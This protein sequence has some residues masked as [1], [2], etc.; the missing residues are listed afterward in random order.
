VVL[1]SLAVGGAERIV[2]DWAQRISADYDVH[3]CVLHK[4]DVEWPVRGGITVTRLQG[5]NVERGLT[6]FAEQLLSLS[7]A[8]GAPLPRVLCHMTRRGHREVLERAGVATVAVLHNALQ[9]WRESFE[10]MRNDRRLVGVSQACLD[11]LAKLGRSEGVSLVRHLPKKADMGVDQRAE[12]RAQ[13]CST[14]GLP[15]GK[16]TKLIAMLGGVK[17]QKNYPRAVQVLEHLTR[18]HNAYLVIFG[19]PIGADGQTCWTSLRQEVVSRGLTSRVRLPGFVPDAAKFLPGFDLMLN[20]SSYEGLSMATLEALAARVPVVATRVGG[21]GEVPSDGLTLVERAA[22]LEQWQH[23]IESTWSKT[24]DVPSWAGFP[25]HRLW[26]LEHLVADVTPRE[27]VLFVTANLNSGGAQRSLVNLTSALN[28]KVSLEVAVTGLS[29]CDAFLTELNIAQVRVS[30]TGDSRDCFDHAEALLRIIAK[31]RAGVVCFWNVDPKIK[32]LLAKV[33]P[34]SVRM[35]DVSPGGYAFEEMA[36]TAAFQTAVAYTQTQF[37]ARLDKL[38]LKYDTPV[39]SDVKCE[40]SVV[41][42]GVPQ[43]TGVIDKLKPRVVL[44]GRIA[45]SKFLLEIVQ[46]MHQVWL[47]RPDIELHVLGNAE[48]RHKGYAQEFQAAIQVACEEACAETGTTPV[49]VLHGAVHDLTQ[50]ANPNDIA[51]VFGHHQGCP[52]AVLEAQALGMTVVAN[53]S[54]GTAEMVRNDQTGVLLPDTDPHALANALLQLLNDD[55]RRA[56]L[57]QAGQQLVQQEFS[58]AAM[59][60]GYLTVFQ[61]LFNALPRG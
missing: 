36:Q 11:D 60:R 55:S 14:L 32:L 4:A 15:A 17:G 28:S 49:V 12:L 45:P 13:L 5:Q 52:N 23:A 38:V 27:H 9:G 42:N 47:R 43:P 21:Q 24:L 40:V 35:V 51:V 48:Q 19:G 1:G 18:T 29:S 22:S 50:E 44:N 34:A 3:L 46:A 61:S 30:R 58:M 25:A 31:Q 7:A 6:Q 16:N 59:T 26:T 57:S 8:H 41:R 56:R 39:P 33:L 53:D 2:L 54:G 10:L 37:Y 20:T